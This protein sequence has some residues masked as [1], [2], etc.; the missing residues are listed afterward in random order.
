MSREYHE[1]AGASQLAGRDLASPEFI[2][3]REKVLN[4]IF[5]DEEAVE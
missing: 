4:I 3:L 5:S 1:G 2:A